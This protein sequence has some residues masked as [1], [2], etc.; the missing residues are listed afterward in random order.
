MCI[1]DRFVTDKEI[2]FQR[3]LLFV[4]EFFRLFRSVSGSDA[5]GI[6]HRIG[7]V[8]SHAVSFAFESDR[9]VTC[10]VGACDFALAGS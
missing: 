1:R 4:E 7:D 9:D 8:H 3:F 5:D 10:C 2:L 6:E